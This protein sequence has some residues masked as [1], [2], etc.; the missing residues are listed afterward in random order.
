MYSA[1]IPYE[2]PASL[3]VCEVFSE[4][5]FDRRI[6]GLLARDNDDWDT[7]NLVK[8]AAVDDVES[9]ERDPRKEEDVRSPSRKE[10]QDLVGRVKAVDLHDTELDV[11]DP[12]AVEPDDK[13]GDARTPRAR[14]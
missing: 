5:A 9:G 1:Q 7:Q 14:Y 8:P 12:E 11:V 4:R 13:E 10:S 6:I 3:P 2:P